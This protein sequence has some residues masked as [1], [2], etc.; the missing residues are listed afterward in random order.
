MK[1][2]S[3][4]W[5]V[6]VVVAVSMVGAT[7]TLAQQAPTQGA[8]DRAPPASAPGQVTPFAVGNFDGK[9]EPVDGTDDRTHLAYELRL[10]NITSANLTLERL[11][12]L[13]PSRGGRVVDVL[14][15]DELD[16]RIIVFGG[17]SSKQFGPG[18][19]GFLFEDVSYPSGARLPEKLN[20]RFD[21]STS[22]PTGL[23][24]SFWAGPTLVVGQEDPMHIGAPLFGKR[25]LTGE[26][27]CDTV[28]SHRAGIFPIDGTFRAQQRVSQ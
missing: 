18:V 14:S 7:A 15:G 19:S 1:V 3:W 22:T 4:R 21:V 9:V 28:T 26:G 8:P 24:E 17:S 5:I 13:D 16:S 2:A 10:T 6:V 27:C 12:V 25:W 20:Y 11:R 23:A